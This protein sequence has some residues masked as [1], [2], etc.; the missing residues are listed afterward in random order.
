MMEFLEMEKKKGK[1]IYLCGQNY[2][3][4][5]LVQHH[6]SSLRLVLELLLQKFIEKNEIS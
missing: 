2:L 4:V 5:I 6:K 1:T 3:K